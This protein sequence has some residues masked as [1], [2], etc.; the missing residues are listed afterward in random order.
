VTPLGKLHAVK[1]RRA[2][3]ADDALREAQQL[4]LDA[5]QQLGTEKDQCTAAEGAMLG[6]RQGVLSGGPIDAVSLRAAIGYGDRLRSELVKQREVVVQAEK[7]LLQAD[8]FAQQAGNARQAAYR[9]REKA[10]Q[11]VERARRDQVLVRA[12]QEDR[13]QEEAA[14]AV[15]LRLFQ[16]GSHA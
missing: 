3:R 5:R 7:S 8:A 12:F 14:E 6:H 4:C 10:S 13:E 15:A 16:R 1:D 9:A 11:M 2:A